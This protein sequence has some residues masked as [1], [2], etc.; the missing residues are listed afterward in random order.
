MASAER[1]LLALWWPTA[2]GASM[3]V[4]EIPVVYAA[5]ARS[6]GGP[7]VLAA[8]GVCVA[9][10]V[11]VNSPGL[12][13]TPLAVTAHGRHSWRRLRR[14]ALLTGLAAALVLAALATVPPLV[15]LVRLAFDADAALLGHIRAGLL[16]L[17][18][19]ALGVALR[20]YLHG[21]LIVTGRTRPIAPATVLRL[22]GTLAL[23]WAGTA[24]WPAHGALV[25]GLAL[26]AGAFTEAAYLAV[27]ARSLPFEPPPAPSPYRELIRRHADVSAARLLVMAPMLVTTI[28]VA[29]S[30]RS[31]A[32]LVVWPALY[33]LAMLF[34]SPT[35]DWESVAAGALRRQPRGTAPRRVT[36]RL[37]VAFTCVFVLVLATGPAG[38]YL[39]GLL[40]VPAELTSFALA[41]SWLLA[42][43]PAL[44]LVRGY[45]RG[46]VMAAV[47]TGWLTAASL[48]HGVALLVCAAA[49][50]STAMPGPAVAGAA[51]VAGLS[52]DVAMTGYGVFRSHAR[53][54]A[55]PSP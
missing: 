45:L 39:H 13:V 31:A 29:H 9:I 23:A 53:D 1:G 35:S 6:A 2:L 55:A 36:V 4:L 48:A 38:V 46:A 44:W 28:A 27:A 14:H 24:L 33:E 10:L 22:L 34:A 19:N 42:P 25:A 5:A 47:A 32:S 12:A 43:V 3:L 8:M 41:W 21:R 37:G 40:A 16:G 17:T 18:P 54:H 50:A 7:L 26:S 15:T 51:V 11:V 30:A 20:R 52:I 49:L